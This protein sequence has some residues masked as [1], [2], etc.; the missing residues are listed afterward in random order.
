MSKLPDIKQDFSQ[1]YNDVIYEAEL[2]DHSPVRGCIV[3]RPYGW[4]MWELIKDHVDKRLKE[5]GHQNAAF[6]LLI[7]ESFLKKEAKHVEGFSPEL[8]VVTHAGGQE[9]EEPLVVRPTSETV[10][11]EMYSRW[12]SS[13]RDLPMLVNQWA[14]VVRWELRPRMFLRTTEFLWQEGHTAHADGDD[15]M[16][17]TMRMLGVYTEVARDICAIPVVPGEKTAGE[18]FAGAMRT[19]SI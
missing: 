17:E 18:R 19:F 12:I 15:A 5:T 9:L 11:G 6:P 1:W 8:A 16:A 10:I 13:W 14:N 4:A 2:A 7:P 3:I